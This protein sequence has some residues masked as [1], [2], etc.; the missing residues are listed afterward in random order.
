[1]TP[2]LKN[3]VQLIGHLGKDV[4]LTVFD[5]GNKKASLSL[6]TNEYYTDKNGEKAKQTEWHNL[7]AWGKTAELMASSL[8]KGN[9][10]AVYGKISSRTYEDKEGTTKYI[11][12]ILVNDFYRIAKSEV[13][14]DADSI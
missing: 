13:T 1:M 12:E 10:V 8:S 11:T 5:N 9:E 3:N 2:M 4:A 7:V 6:A 14:T